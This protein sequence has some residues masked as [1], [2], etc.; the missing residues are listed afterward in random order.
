[1]NQ[2]QGINPGQVRIDPEIIKRA[3]LIKCDCG[4]AIFEEKMMLKRIS[5]I[6]SPT[7]QEEMF[8]MN[9]LVCTKCGMV[10]TALNPG[11]MIPTEYLAKKKLSIEE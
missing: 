7:G 3:I 8:P 11:D 2:G 9:V 1:M 4:G 10:P 5:P 6:V